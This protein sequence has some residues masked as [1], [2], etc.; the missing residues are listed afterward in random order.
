[1]KDKRQIEFRLSAFN[2]L[3]HPLATFNGNGA[4]SDLSLLFAAP[5]A[6]I[7]NSNSVTTGFPRYTTGYRMGLVSIKYKF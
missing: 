4:N 3:N 7:R 6:G 1:M 5:V 2:F